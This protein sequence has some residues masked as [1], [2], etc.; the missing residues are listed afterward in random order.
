MIVEISDKLAT[1]LNQPKQSKLNT[2]YISEEVVRY[3]Y[4]NH[5]I[6]SYDS[7]IVTLDSTLQRLLELPPTTLP[8]V[9]IAPHLIKQYNPSCTTNPP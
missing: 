3:I 1:F 7:R 2:R 8:L 5:L 4:R 9:D 6:I